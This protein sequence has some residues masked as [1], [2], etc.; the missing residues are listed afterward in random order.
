MTS[1][2]DAYQLL[3]RGDLAAAGAAFV[4]L[5]RS[6]SGPD[7]ARALWGLG[8]VASGRAEDRD[9]ARCFAECS[10]LLPGEP[11]PLIALGE[12]LLQLREF[13]RAGIAFETA[14]ASQPRYAPAHY[15]LGLYQLGRGEKKPA[16]QSFRR[17][18]ELQ[19]DHCHALWSLA[20]LHRFEPGDPLLA[21]LELQLAKAGRTRDQMLLHYAL[22][23]ARDALADY[24]SAFGHWQQANALQLAST[25]YRVED[26]AG[27]FADLR[28]TFSAKTLALRA[29]TIPD[30]P[31]PLFILGQP[32]SGSTLLEQMLSRHPAIE[33]A[34][35]RRI[36]GNQLARRLETMTGEAYP[37]GCR[38]LDSTQLGQLGQAY[39]EALPAAVQG[40]AVVIDKLP[41][42][43]Q[44]VGWIRMMLPQAVIVH[45]QRDARDT[46]FSIFRH[47]FS[48][49]EPFF[50]G[51]RQIALYHRHYQ[52]TMAFWREQLPGEVIEVEYAALTT[53]PERALRPILAAAGL[54]W[55]PALLAP[56]R[57]TDFVATLSATQ[58][59]EPI[60][61]R[62]G[63]W[64][65]Y[66]QHLGEWLALLPG[67][68]D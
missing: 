4:A 44:S 6:A 11:E 48:Q 34:G 18:L 26:M 12:A 5:L 51:L 62:Q 60:T 31:R 16:E 56:E 33:S 58:V 43:F 30:G 3:N 32:R 45:L 40:A 1:L 67:T 52:D 54:D 59:R 35:E 14:L 25:T 46:A 37:R 41:A 50:C 8:R 20:R 49:T 24:D 64:R 39:L 7:R 9:A 63:A 23:T 13:D 21:D 36:L 2:D 38:T 57:G 19:P 55:H 15:A 65:N 28:S 10:Q 29:A 27:Y 61:Q 42:N 53:A 22:G 66:Q 17:T 47:Y 68:E